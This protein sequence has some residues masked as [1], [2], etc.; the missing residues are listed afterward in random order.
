L[1]KREKINPV[2]GCLPV[3]IQIPVFFALYKV[4]YITIEMRHQPFFGWIHDLSAPDP[5]S[6]FNLFG[7]LPFVPPTIL[8]LGAWPLVLG[9]TMFLQM[10]L[11]P[12]PQDPVQ[13]SMFRWMPLIFTFM[14][15]SFPAGLVIYYSWN[16]TLSILQ[17]SIIMKKNGVKI[18]LW[19]NLKSLFNR[20]PTGTKAVDTKG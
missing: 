9:V 18:E 3:L 4:L 14:M 11:N 8:M 17:Q 13:A 6:V 16:N 15:A 7:L 1:Y 12:A 10:Q 20:K 5:T 2:S 19:D